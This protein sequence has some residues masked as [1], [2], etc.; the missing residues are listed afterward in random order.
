MGEGITITNRI[1][2]PPSEYGSTS[3]ATCPEFLELGT[4]DVVGVIGTADTLGRLVLPEDV[5]LDT[6][7]LLSQT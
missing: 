7:A 5:V 4:D 6:L 2:L 1:G 3:G